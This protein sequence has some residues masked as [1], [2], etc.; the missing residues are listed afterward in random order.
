[1]TLRKPAASSLLTDEI[2]REQS[3]A[4]EIIS[5]LKIIIEHLSRITGETLDKE[6]IE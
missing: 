2:P 1:M 4:E 3:D 5:L 6:D